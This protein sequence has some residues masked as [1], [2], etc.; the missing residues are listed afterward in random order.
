MGD[1]CLTFQNST[2]V[3]SL[4]HVFVVKMGA[5]CCIG[6]SGTSC[7]VLYCSIQDEEQSSTAL[8]QKFEISHSCSQVLN[9]LWQLPLYTDL[10]S[11]FVCGMK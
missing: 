3:P 4:V 5:P 7:L 10:G 8:Q 9:N 1:W 2:V 6:T 11:G